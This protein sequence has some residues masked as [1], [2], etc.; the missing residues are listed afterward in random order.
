V[1][2]RAALDRP[3]IDQTGISGRYDFDLEWLPDE[4]QFG[5]LGLKPNP[6][7]PKPDLY[8]AVQQQLGLRLEATTGPV[9]VLIV[10]RAEK[11]SEN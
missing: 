4:T 8:A 5:G 1:L 7:H 9:D 2:Q 10:D 11:P 3:V 6:D